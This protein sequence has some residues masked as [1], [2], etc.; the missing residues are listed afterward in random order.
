M[1]NIFGYHILTNE[2]SGAITLPIYDVSYTTRTITNNFDSQILMYLTNSS[3]YFCSFSAEVQVSGGAEEEP[4]YE[5]FEARPVFSS[6]RVFVGVLI[7]K[8]GQHQLI[9]SNWDMIKTVKVFYFYE[10]PVE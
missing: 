8:D 5:W 7:Y 6:D 3:Y 10:Q 1:K 2:D 4:T 9:H